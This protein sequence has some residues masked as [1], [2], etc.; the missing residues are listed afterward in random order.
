VSFSGLVPGQI[1]RY[2]VTFTIP[3]GVAL[4]DRVPVELETQGQT[5]PAATLVVR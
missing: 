4:G 3:A 5:S 1:G 2:Q